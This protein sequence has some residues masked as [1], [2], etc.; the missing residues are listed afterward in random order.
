MTAGMGNLRDPRGVGFNTGATNP[1]HIQEVMDS[2]S[3]LRE[4]PSQLVGTVRGLLG[5]AGQPAAPRRRAI[6][7]RTL[8]MI[9]YYGSASSKSF[10]VDAS[11]LV[12]VSG[13]PWG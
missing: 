9:S 1:Q 8:L 13:I 6:P 10:R 2:L 5:Y 3:K 4:A 12:Y 7:F 11:V